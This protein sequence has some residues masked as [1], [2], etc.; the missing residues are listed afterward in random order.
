MTSEYP[1]IDTLFERG[2]DFA[3]DDRKLRRA[4]F[5]L[6]SS[7]LVTE[8][9]DGTN[10][11]VSLTQ[12]SEGSWIRRFGG[13]TDRAQIPAALV[14]RLDALFPVEKLKSVCRGDELYS[15]TLYGEGYGA[16]IQKGGGDYSPTPEF[17]LFDVRVGEWWLEWKDV[18]DVAHKLGIQTVPVWGASATIGA[19]SHFVKS[20]FPSDIG[21][22]QAE[23]VVCRTIP[24]LYDKRGH[25]LKWKLKTKD[26]IAGKRR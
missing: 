11:R 26:F 18:C 8:K 20:A 1:K 23:G 16:K 4:E 17:A 22:A 15:F 5:G 12:D 21:M 10:I 7:W 25:P 13:R 24:T 6:V 2:E 19:V 14:E 3:V 9:I